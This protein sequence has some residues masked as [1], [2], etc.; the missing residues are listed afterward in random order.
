MKCRVCESNCKMFLDLGRQPIANNFLTPE[1]FKD[2]WFYNLQVYFCPDCFTVQIGECPDSSQVFNENYSFFTGSSALMQKH[3]AELA[4]LIKE[5]YL[6]KNGCIMEIG[7]NDGTFL[8][9]FKNN[10]HL[11][12]DPS[13]SVNEVARSKG[14]RVY[15][16]PF[17]GFGDVSEAWPKTDIFVS[18]NAFAHIPKRRGVLTQLKNMLALEGV[19]ID[20]EPYL[21][22]IISQLEYDQFYNEH[23]FYTSI[24]SMQK[25][26]AIF[27]L[28]IMDFEFLWTHGGSIRY[29]VGHRKPGLR[30]KV[31]DAI[32]AEGLDNFNVFRR[33]GRAV[34]I[35]AKGFRQELI[36]FKKHLVGYAASAKSTTVLNY[37]QIGP[38][39]IDCIYD[40]TP[41]KQGKLSPGV[42][43]PIV[44]Y[45][46]FKE[47]NPSD[48]V[49]FACNHFKEIMQKEAG[50]ERNWIIPTG[51]I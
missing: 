40:T 46:E 32:K 33:F 30:T 16:F 3:F 38:E 10:V 42:H 20:E 25:T 48:V 7:S 35:Q 21:G 5:K 8:D 37:C 19:W 23:I 9:H 14:V 11:G 44:P 47:D 36:D 39:V 41:V 12:F 6:P 17:E 34:E 45:D 50:V 24:A 18:C 15:P 29:F 22:N 27:D 1:N 13:E 2:E 31:E 51:G 49:L 43:I 4:D 28:E 26:L